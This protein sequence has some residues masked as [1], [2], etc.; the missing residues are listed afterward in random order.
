MNAEGGGAVAIVTDEQRMPYNRP[1]LTKELLRG[2]MSERELPLED[3]AW[4][5]E[6]ELSLISGRAVT[7]DILPPLPGGR[8]TGRF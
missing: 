1:P 2:E 6:H 8:I 5:S 7:L 4:L 3:E